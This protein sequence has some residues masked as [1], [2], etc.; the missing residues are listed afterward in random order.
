MRGPKPSHPIELTDAE[1]EQLHRLVRAH[2]T[3]Q[4]LAIR[5]R[6]VLAAS[7]HSEWSNQQNVHAVDTS[8]RLVRKWR[9]RWV[10]THSLADAPRSG[11]PRRFS[12][13]VRAQATA[14]A[15]SLPQTRE[16]PL[17]RWSRTELARWVAAAPQLPNVSA[18]TIGRW[19]KAER[20]RPWRYHA[21]QHIQDPQTFWSALAQCCS[22]MNKP[23]A[24]CEKEAGWSAWM[25]KRPFKLAK[26]NRLH[27]QPSESRWLIS[28]HVTI[29]TACGI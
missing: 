18:S 5:A 22:C 29:V 8:D 26:R 10:A 1:G 6:I 25:R 28:H 20:L 14:V 2:T 16:V 23:L 11:A 9:Q 17:A 19:L 7:E 24:C 4:T 27:G 12:P 15:C 3:G 21:W 13:E